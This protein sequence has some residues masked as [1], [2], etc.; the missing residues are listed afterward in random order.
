MQMHACSD[1]YYGILK[2]KHAP[3]GCKYANFRH[4]TL[5]ISYREARLSFAGTNFAFILLLL[6]LPSSK[7]LTK[8]TH[9]TWYLATTCCQRVLQV[10]K[11]KGLVPTCSDGSAGHAL[12][13]LNGRLFKP[14]LGVQIVGSG[15]K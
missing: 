14:V 10:E 3:P 9:I 7:V 2:P 5:M 8:D 12:T 15:A 13:V 11:L 1:E 6:F 4:V